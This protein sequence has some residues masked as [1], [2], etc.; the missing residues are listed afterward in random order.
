VDVPA[1]YFVETV[2]KAIK[3]EAKDAIAKSQIEAS[4]AAVYKKNWESAMKAG[5]V[6]REKARGRMEKAMKEMAE[7]EVE[8]DQKDARI[9]DLEAEIRAKDA[10][11][12]E[13][14]ARIQA[15]NST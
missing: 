2:L 6:S 13:L 9:A 5:S 7:L 8:N 4:N 1:N 15:M 14:E 3:K 11:I 12:A 10:K